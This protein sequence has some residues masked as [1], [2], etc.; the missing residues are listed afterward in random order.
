M[1]WWIDVLD[2]LINELIDK[3][4]NK[5]TDLRTNISMDQLKLSSWINGF[6]VD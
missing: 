1:H 6:C 2:R 5:L 3:W 4:I